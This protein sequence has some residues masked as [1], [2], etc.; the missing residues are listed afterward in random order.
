MRLT[1]LLTGIALT[2][3][4]ATAPALAQKPDP[5]N[6]QF[7]YF[8]PRTVV[9]AAVTQR[10]TACPVWQSG[11]RRLEG[12][13][14]LT[15]IVLGSETSADPEAKYTVDAR[16]GFLSSRSTK[17]TLRP[18]GTLDSFNVES[19][20]Q[21]GAILKSVIT[22]AATVATWGTPAMAAPI[23]MVAAGV[24]RGG[25]P[26]NAFML[27]APPVAARAPYRC[28]TQVVDA[29]K[30]LDVLK[31]E[32]SELEAQTINGAITHALEQRRAEEAELTAKLTLPAG[33]GTEFDP[34]RTD[35][36]PGADGNLPVREAMLPPP[37]Y[38]TWFQRWDPGLRTYVDATAADTAEL[39]RLLGVSSPCPIPGAEGFRATLAADKAMFGALA[40]QPLPAPARVQRFV[41]YRRP[42]PAQLVVRP[43]R[44]AELSEVCKSAAH[45]PANTRASQW[46]S[47]PQLSGTYSFSI[48]SGGL[49]G[50]RQAMV[51]LDAS[52]A[53]IALEYGSES[54]S[55]DIA[56]VVDGSVAAGETFR[57][58]QLTA[59]NRAIE[60]ITAERSLL[61]L[62]AGSAA[63]DEPE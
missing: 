1:C 61:E 44:A 31:Q 45:S 55:D 50:T 2:A 3:L 63:E 48:G 17:L 16:A 57:N 23:G 36:I 33:I 38:V 8:L 41:H 18:D 54:G 22:A 52:G 62:L 32:I 5:L 40:G 15:A 34:N 49:F 11:T 4:T 37:R 56:A 58:R 7:D 13:T 24:Q 29:L 19:K 51:K 39:V 35:F 21:G 10:I 12:F 9:G 6:R 14:L 27:A 28:N 53:P 43:F 47:L 46:F 25:M 30:R 59:N 60:L 42:V 26:R 20:G